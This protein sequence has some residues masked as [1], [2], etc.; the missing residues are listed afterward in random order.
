MTA[1]SGTPAYVQVAGDLRSQIAR[2]DLPSGAKLPSNSEL[3]EHYSVSNTVIRDAINEL[4]REGLVVGQQGKGVFVQGKGGGASQ[5]EGAQVE[6]LAD[7]VQELED[8]IG[9]GEDTSPDIQALR[10]ELAEL[11]E[12]VSALRGQLIKLYHLVGRPYQGE[13]TT[14]RGSREEAG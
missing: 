1:M 12:T 9:K 7:R 11:R 14:T 8:R 5:P 13:E 2:G 6:E 3:R 4:R 10:G